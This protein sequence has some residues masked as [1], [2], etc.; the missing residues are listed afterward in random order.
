MFKMC[1]NIGKFHRPFLTFWLLPINESGAKPF[2]KM[3][4]A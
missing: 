3:G 4:S 2:M 1:E